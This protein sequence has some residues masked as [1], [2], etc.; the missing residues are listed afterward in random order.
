MNGSADKY[1]V[2]T[3]HPKTGRYDRWRIRW[4]LPPDPYSGK[5][6][7]GT[8]AGF[9]T[10]GEAEAALADVLG[11]VNHGTYVA[12][13]RQRLGDYLTSWLDGLRVKPTTRDNYRTQ[14]EVHIV[15]RLGGVALCDLTAEQV[16][17]LYRQL[18]KHGK[19]AGT[20]RTAGVTCQ[21]HGCAPERHDGLAPKSVRHAHTALRKAL[22]DAV[23]RGY[24]G[25]NVADLANPPTQRDARSKRARDKAWSA[26]VLR[27]F[28]E[29][30]S[31]DRLAPLW[32]LAATTGL[33]RAELCGLRWS[34]VDLDR[35]RLTVAHTVTEVRG[36]KIDQD[37]GKSDAAERSLAL[38][39][40]TVAALRR[41]K[42]RQAKERLAWPVDRPDTDLVF[43]REDG[44]GHR[45]KRLSSTFTEALDR[46]GL[47]R[48]GLHGLR[49]SYATAALRAG[50][51][52]EV[53]A[54]RLGHASVVVTLSIY[55]HVFEQDD[56]AAA[57]RVADAIFGA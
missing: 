20:C 10:R 45:P 40:R 18:E 27:G 51:S 56:Q 46:L 41:W 39:S 16:D 37:H 6:R 53:L 14:V 12:P 19:R 43:T 36:Q 42:R 28:L 25:R 54:K 47:Q 29:D 38:D 1:R 32:L 31:D 34:D 24:L 50:V 5:R 33:R 9:A 7:R 30:A 57:E 21:Q 3:R 26:D 17:G 23:D 48:I 8:R 4:E 11:Q 15:P 2:R 49:H 13:S 44:E 35:R 52:P 22:Q 55:A